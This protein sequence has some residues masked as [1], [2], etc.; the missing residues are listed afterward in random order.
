MSQKILPIGI[1]SFNQLRERNGYYVDKTNLIYN[2]IMQ[3]GHYFLSRPRRFG[4][5]LLLSTIKYVF[6][7]RRELFQGLDIYSKYDWNKT[8]PV[9]HLSLGNGDYSSE[10]SFKNSLSDKIRTLEKQYDCYD[11]LL[12]TVSG[13]FENIIKHVCHTKK[14][15]VVI[16][17]DEYDAPILKTITKRDVAIKNSDFLKDFYTTLK[18]C[19]DEIRFIFLV[20]I[21]LFSKL[22]LFLD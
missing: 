17:I 15:K 22:N 2:L 6:E 10:S 19:S 9:I 14:A 5:S 13:R 1:Q 7:G 18:D 12:Q 4:K 16:L 8:Y 3:G 21:S 11:P 20:G